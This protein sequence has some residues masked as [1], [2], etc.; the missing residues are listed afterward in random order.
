M[1]PCGTQLDLPKRFFSGHIQ[2]ARRFAHFLTHLQ[3]KRG[4][5]DTR[6]TA[7]QY[8]RAVYSTAAQHSIQFSDTG[9]K[10]AFVTAVNILEQRGT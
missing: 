4:F 8:K 6:F 2:D 9:V 1:Q 5:A 10:P 7:H 3:Q